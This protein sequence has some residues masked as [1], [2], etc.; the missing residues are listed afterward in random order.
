MTPVRALLLLLV[1]ATG[2]PGPAFNPKVELL[3]RTGLGV[4]GGSSYALASSWQGFVIPNGADNEA[5][6]AVVRSGDG[7]G[8]M[9]R[10]RPST[11][12]AGNG[13]R[14]QQLSFQ[15]VEFGSMDA[16][17]D[18]AYPPTTFCGPMTSCPASYSAALVAPRSLS[19]QSLL[20]AV[21]LASASPPETF[22]PIFRL[23]RISSDGGL[24][25]NTGIVTEPFTQQVLATALN[26]GPFVVAF[27][28]GAGFSSKG[29]TVQL[30]S[31]DTGSVSSSS[32]IDS[33]QLADSGVG[34]AATSAPSVVRLVPTRSGFLA[35]GQTDLSRDIACGTQDNPR[36][37]G[38]GQS[39]THAMLVKFD[40]TGKQLWRRDLGQE[41]VQ[42]G[43]FFVDAVELDDGSVVATGQI[44]KPALTWLEPEFGALVARFSADGAILRATRFCPCLPFSKQGAEALALN[45][46]ATSGGYEV[47]FRDHQNATATRFDLNDSLVAAELLPRKGLKQQFVTTSAGWAFLFERT[48]GVVELNHV[49]FAPR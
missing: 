47:M 12:P 41:F 34:I 23:L 35:V 18:V 11:R 44:E 48:P 43:S 25:L 2:C 17:V 4:D 49:E 40:Q 39:I 27:S 7:G 38:C 14:L 30:R 5:Q 6:L 36:P 20:A 26:D 32:T 31:P 45:P 8:S 3:E 1:C 24:L 28:R 9:M 29:V 46:R 21:R 42:P 10:L 13:G 15:R 37:G 16:G 19:D 22:E 33:T